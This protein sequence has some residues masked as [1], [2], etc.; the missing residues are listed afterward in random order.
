MTFYARNLPHW[1]PE[2]ADIFI[3]WRLYGSLPSTMKIP[4]QSES[5][6]ERFRRFDL[7]LDRAGSGP[8]WLKHPRIAKCVIEALAKGQSREMF[9]LHSYVVMANHVH[10]LIEPHAPISRI[11]QWIKGATARNANMIL[12][13]SGNH[14]WQDESFDR[15]IRNTQQWSLVK[16]YIE[17][18]PVTAGLVEAAKDWPWSSA[19]RPIL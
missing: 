12:G 14:F 9:R 16:T 10:V 2:G 7:E 18:N 5:A 19:S 6:G 17:K 8:V 3:T 4:K 15:W 11:T 13:R 1:Q